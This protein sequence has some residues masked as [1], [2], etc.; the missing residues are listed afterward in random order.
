MSG[1]I[2]NT[3]Y[4]TSPATSPIGKNASWQ[5]ESAKVKTTV[6]KSAT[7]RLDSSMPSI[8]P[9]KSLDSLSF[10]EVFKEHAPFSSE[11]ASARDRMPL[12]S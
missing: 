10:A 6:N 9:Q 1:A 11:N 12:F 8:C 7:T 5:K 3:T 2:A 4:T